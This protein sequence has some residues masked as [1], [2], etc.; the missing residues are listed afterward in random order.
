MQKVGG[1]TWRAELSQR[2]L[3]MMAVSGKTIKYDATVIAKNDKGQTTESSSPI[4]L[5]IKAP[6]VADTSS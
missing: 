2:Q 6:E 1:T 3:Q 5:A 4:T